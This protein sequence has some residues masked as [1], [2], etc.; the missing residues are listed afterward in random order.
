VTSNVLQFSPKVHLPPPVNCFP[1]WVTGVRHFP[2]RVVIFPIQAPGGRA[3]R[4]RQH[5]FTSYPLHPTP[6]HMA[7][8]FRDQRPQV[9]SMFTFKECNP[10]NQIYD[11]PLLCCFCPMKSRIP[12]L[13]FCQVFF[14]Y[15]SANYL[16]L[17]TSFINHL[18]SFSYFLLHRGFEFF[19][20]NHEY[21]R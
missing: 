3:A 9:V 12:H 14:S 15:R 4:V 20:C 5:L 6:F 2:A 18:R 10:L 7:P 19:L 11:F 8:L 13:P 16:R 21:A 1:D 17:V